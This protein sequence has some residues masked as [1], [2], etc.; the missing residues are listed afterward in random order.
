MRVRQ[1]RAAK[2]ENTRKA[3]SATSVYFDSLPYR[4]DPASGI[5][6]YDQLARDARILDLRDFVTDSKP[7]VVLLGQYSVGK[8]SF[9]RYLLGRDFPGQRIGTDPTTDRFVAIVRGESGDKIVPGAALCSQGRLALVVMQRINEMGK[10]VRAVKD[11]SKVHK[12]EKKMV[13]EMD[14]VLAGGVQVR[15]ERG[16][17][18]GG[19]CNV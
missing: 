11:L 8:T 13:K 17:R 3:V 4:V 16:M 7:M 9:I 1:P 18:G 19:E 15:V 14:R 2:K 6:D 12:L 5:V 10:R